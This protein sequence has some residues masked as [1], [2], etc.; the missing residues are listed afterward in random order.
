MCLR[1]DRKFYGLSSLS[2]IRGVRMNIFF[3]MPLRVSMV[4]IILN[5]NNF[6]LARFL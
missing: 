1:N 6:F 4:K 5:V 3:F 2:G